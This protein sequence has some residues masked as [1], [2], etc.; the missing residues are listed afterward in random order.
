MNQQPE[1]CMHLRFCVLFAQDMLF[2][3]A[4]PKQGGLSQ[5]FQMFLT[6]HEANFMV[7][8]S[9]QKKPDVNIS[10]LVGVNPTKFLMK[11]KVKR[12]ENVSSRPSHKQAPCHRANLLANTP[13]YNI[14]SVRG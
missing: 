11:L 4:V 1:V 5:S 10:L 13:L 12:R 6:L 7:F 8:Y 14:A 9:L 3:F 2:F